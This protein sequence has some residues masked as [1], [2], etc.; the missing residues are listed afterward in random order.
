MGLP[1]LE[2]LVGGSR[3]HQLDDFVRRDDDGPPHEGYGI[4]ALAAKKMLT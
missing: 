3:R 4:A 2:Q 1:G